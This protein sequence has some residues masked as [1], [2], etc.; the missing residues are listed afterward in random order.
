MSI[1]DCEDPPSSAI[2]NSYGWEV[3]NVNHSDILRMVTLMADHW[4]IF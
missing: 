1:V 2:V 4:N 3:L